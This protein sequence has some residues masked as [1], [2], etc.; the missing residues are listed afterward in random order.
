MFN[1][2][3]YNLSDT[4]HSIRLLGIFPYNMSPTEQPEAIAALVDLHIQRVQ[5]TLAP[6]FVLL[7]YTEF[8]AAKWYSWMHPDGPEDIWDRAERLLQ[9][10]NKNKGKQVVFL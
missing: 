3:L 5:G 8:C 4:P 9:E 10:K 7:P 2:F 1:K 6:G